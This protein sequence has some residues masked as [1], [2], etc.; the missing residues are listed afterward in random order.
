MLF[1][2]ATRRCPDAKGFE[3]GRGIN[4]FNDFR[5]VVDTGDDGEVTRGMLDGT[6]MRHAIDPIPTNII[7]VAFLQV[8]FTAAEEHEL[9][10]GLCSCLHSGDGFVIGKV[11]VKKDIPEIGVV[12]EGVNDLLDV[13]KIL[14]VGNAGGWEQSVVGI[15][16]ND[17]DCLPDCRGGTAAL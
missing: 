2:G 7:P 15:D 8:E 1:V 5:L 10:P 3:G 6:E 13:I 14:R 12:D 11:F 4:T 9:L 17:G 16:Q